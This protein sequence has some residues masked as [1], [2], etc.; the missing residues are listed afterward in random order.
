MGISVIHRFR[1]D[2]E[3]MSK[4]QPAGLRDRIM[5]QLIDGIVL[6]IITG[7]LLALFSRGRIYSLW[8]SPILPVYLVQAAPDCLSA[9]KDWWWGGRF[10]TISPPLLSDFHLSYPAPL[11]W[12]IYAAYYSLFHSFY[13]QTPGKMLKGLVVLDARNRFLSLPAAFLRWT[14]YLVSLLP[15]GLGFW[16][17][18]FHS[19]GLTWH[20]RMT[21]T[22]VWRF[23]PF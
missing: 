22:S 15:L 9:A 10:I 6:G 19:R 23:L 1:F 4:L 2:N 11:L 14:G 13:G 3:Q 17:S 8:I 12:V 18:V 21:G 5:A 20:D 7:L 16:S